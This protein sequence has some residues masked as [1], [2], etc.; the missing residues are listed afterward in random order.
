MTGN[1]SPAC[2]RASA[3]R[4]LG[5]SLGFLLV[6]AL[7][8]LLVRGLLS[9]PVDGDEK[10]REYFGDAAPPFGLALSE[11][12]RLPTQDVLVRFVRDASADASAPAPLEA[13]FLEYESR[14]AVD[15]LFRGGMDEGPPGA[16]LKEWEKD[17]SFAWRATL[18]RDEIAWGPWRSKLVIE[19]SFHEGGGWQDAARVDLSRAERPLVLYVL[20]PLETPADE[21]QLVQLLLAVQMGEPASQPA[22]G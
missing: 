15:V 14:A 20:W 11:A 4:V 5:T 2:E 12:V 9:R 22:G 21:K 6:L 13:S 1:G 16:R 3:L 19:R 7:G 10:A 8:F 18:K 17:K